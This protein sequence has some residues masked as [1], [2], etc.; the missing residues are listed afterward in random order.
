MLDI[1][2]GRRLFLGAEKTAARSKYLETEYKQE[3]VKMKGFYR[4][5]ATIVLVVGTVA[6]VRSESAIADNAIVRV[7]Q[8]TPGGFAFKAVTD[9]M[10]LWRFLEPDKRPGDY[11]EVRKIRLSVDQRVATYLVEGKAEP[12]FGARRQMWWIVL[13]DRNGVY[14]VIGDLDA[15]DGVR[16]ARAGMRNGFRDILVDIP[17]TNFDPAWSQRYG[18]NGLRYVE[19]GR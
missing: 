18:Y 8:G 10:N 7:E 5:I 16:I 19:I 6:S 9:S 17:A 13:C 12:Y 14:R 1:Y 4:I 11:V 3:E 2:S 15:A